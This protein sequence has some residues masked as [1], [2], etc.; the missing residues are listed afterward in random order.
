MVMAT[1]K[2]WGTPK[3]QIDKFIQIHGDDALAYCEREKA[4]RVAKGAD[5]A[6]WWWGSMA[7]QVRRRQ[8][9]KA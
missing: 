4:K 3:E 8:E 6:A 7:D 2:G 9:E 5:I 1:K